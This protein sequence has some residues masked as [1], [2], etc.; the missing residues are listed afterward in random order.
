MSVCIHEGTEIGGKNQNC[1]SA[2]K[3]ENLG[4]VQY[5]SGSGAGA[6][7]FC[8]IGKGSVEACP[9]FYGVL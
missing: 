2:I 8:Q 4:A 6:N 3:S 7:S 9:I 1:R 5:I